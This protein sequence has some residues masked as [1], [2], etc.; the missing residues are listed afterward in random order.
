M[1]KIWLV[2]LLGLCVTAARADAIVRTQAMTAS[3]IAEFF[4]ED[5]GT[6][7]ELE[8]GIDDVPAFR[9]LLPDVIHERLDLPPRPLAERL[10]DF[11]AMD[12]T[13]APF[14]STPLPGRVL[15]M[16][17]RDR[18]RRDEITGEPLPAQG[19]KEKVIFAELLY[20]FETRPEG[21][22]LS[23]PAPAS[24]GF[25]VYHHG[26][27]VND[28][29]YLGRGYE[30][31]LNWRDPWYSRFRGRNLR[32]TYDAAMSGFLYIEPYEVRKEIIA[33]PL[34]LARWLDLDLEDEGVI[35]GAVQSELLRRIADFLLERHP[36]IIDGN[37]IEPELARINFLRRTL[38]NSTVIDPPEDLDT[39]SATVGAIFVYPTDGLPQQVTMEWD[40]F[41][42]QI[43][44]VPAAAVDHAG[45]LPSFLTPEDPVLVWQNFLKNPRLPTLIAT[46]PPPPA[47]ARAAAW[48][49]WLLAVG[50][51]AFV[52][53][54]AARRRR[55][56]NLSR[57]VPVVA[58]A[59]LVLTG[60][61]FWLGHDARLSESR[62]REL[63]SALLHNVYR[64]F[65]YRDEER[66]Y[67]V[68]EQSVAGDLLTEIYLETRRGLEIQ[69][70][71]GAR[72]KVE[73]LELTELE[74]ESATRGGFLARAIW[75]V[76]GSVGH[77]GHV[78]RRT[79]RY[80]AGLGIEPV[81]GVWKLTSLDLLEEER[82]VRG[83]GG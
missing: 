38:R 79:N 12:L 15:L 20:P 59:L 23:G 69:N 5:S 40:L 77:W 82:L 80:R 50:A 81:D 37:E 73:E 27:P 63:V 45:P 66:I 46:E 1:R 19:A 4:I 26:L 11:F 24:I 7:V 64:A 10:P 54:A 67:D 72:A 76:S 47:A 71:G 22:T 56:R 78:H 75:S 3:T 41:A 68:L 6:R 51:L 62:K 83:P 31:E 57:S 65:D 8:I 44:K 70:Q 25:V 43:D 14:G 21:L 33:R 53:N 29:R 49:R 9:N 30:L 18:L 39:I 16:E 34:D 36:V 42:P 58:A 74:T 28:F 52:G 35:P 48:L 32:R 17:L 2:I 60:A 61:A 55:D 13:V